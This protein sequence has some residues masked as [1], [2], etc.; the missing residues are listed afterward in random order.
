MADGLIW[1]TFAFIEPTSYRL[2]LTEQLGMIFLRY[3]HFE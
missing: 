2:P 3:Q 1:I